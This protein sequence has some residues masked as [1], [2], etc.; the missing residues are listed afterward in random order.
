MY[1]TVGRDVED[2]VPYGHEISA[3]HNRRRAGVV[4][5]Y[6]WKNISAQA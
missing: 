2:A 5:P 4:A 1:A 3:K 6:G